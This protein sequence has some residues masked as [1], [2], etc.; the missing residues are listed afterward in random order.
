MYDIDRLEYEERRE[1][2]RVRRAENAKRE[3]LSWWNWLKVS[4]ISM[5]FFVG[6]G[7]LPSRQTLTDPLF[8]SIV[9][10]I[11]WVTCLAILWEWERKDSGF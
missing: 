3:S 9:F 11:G 6:I 8:D 2:R 5:A 7:L 10:G 1:A 4:I